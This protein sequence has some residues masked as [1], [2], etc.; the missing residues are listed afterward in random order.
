MFMGMFEF[1]PQSMQCK[2]TNAKIFSSSHELSD[3]RPSAAP[4]AL[5]MSYAQTWVRG[6]GGVA[7]KKDS[8]WSVSHS[9]I[10]HHRPDRPAT[11][12]QSTG[13]LSSLRSAFVRLVLKR[14]SSHITSNLL[15][16][17]SSDCWISVTHT[18]WNTNTSRISDILSEIISS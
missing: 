16:I 8:H 17:S 1:S 2:V 4:R 12:K 13:F 10:S 5:R 11:I 15:T 6:V 7:V 3:C 14:A 9:L 18:I